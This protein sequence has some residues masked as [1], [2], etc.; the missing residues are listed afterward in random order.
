MSNEAFVQPN[1]SAL[2]PGTV[3]DLQIELALTVGVQLCLKV[4][5][6]PIPTH[7]ASALVRSRC[8]SHTA[9]P[10]VVH[11]LHLWNSSLEWQMDAN[12]INLH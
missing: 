8:R 10:P 6:Q 7:G 2:T 4:V 12:C 3:R 11:R 1:L 9:G 5:E